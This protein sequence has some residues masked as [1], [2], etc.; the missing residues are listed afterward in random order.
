[1]G[2]ILLQERL[3]C[4][5]GQNLLV[6]AGF[7]GRRG[8]CY[9]FNDEVYGADY[10]RRFLLFHCRRFVKNSL[11]SLN[12]MVLCSSGWDEVNDFLRS[13]LALLFYKPVPPS[14]LGTH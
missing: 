4:T 7:G 14:E 11:E 8:R 10:L 13:L 12:I 9:F 6:W 1:M 3:I 5:L 2:C